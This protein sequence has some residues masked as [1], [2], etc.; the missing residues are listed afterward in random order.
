MLHFSPSAFSDLAILQ[1]LFSAFWAIL[2][3]QSGFDK[4]VDWKGNLAWL[5]GHFSKS[6]LHSSVP[7][8]LGTI[9][10]LEIAAGAS[11]LVGIVQ[12]IWMDSFF[13]AQIGT[14][15]SAISLLMLFFGQRIAKDYAG[16]ASI[17]LYFFAAMFNLWLLR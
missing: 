9:T 8:L 15:L 4:L 5:T 11:S 6:F 12:I 10:F 17:A 3:L 7:I 16:A 2:F 1:I 13:L 14:L